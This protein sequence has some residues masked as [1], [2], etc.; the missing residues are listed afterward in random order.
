MSYYVCQW[1]VKIKRYCTNEKKI[2]LTF[3]ISYMKFI[4]E[5]FNL[6]WNHVGNRICLC[7]YCEI[8][9]SQSLHGRG[10]TVLT[11]IRILC[12]ILLPCPRSNFAHIVISTCFWWWWLPPPRPKW[13]RTLFSVRANCKANK[14]CRRSDADIGTAGH[15]RCGG[16]TRSSAV[17]ERPRDCSCHWI[18]L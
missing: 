18:F 13:H 11:S 10:C 6:T 16:I 2:A 1:S 5:I 15:M 17:A 8:M 7:M 12:R 4:I 9:S 14:K 3:V